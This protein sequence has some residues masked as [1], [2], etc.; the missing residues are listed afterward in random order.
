MFQLASLTCI[1]S[2]ALYTKRHPSFAYGL[3]SL[4]IRSSWSS[5]SA[6]HRDT[7]PRLEGYLRR[8]NDGRSKLVKIP[9]FFSNAHVLFQWNALTLT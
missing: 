7:Q 8:K 5:Q 2:T 9:N 3:L 6:Q 1:T 4:I